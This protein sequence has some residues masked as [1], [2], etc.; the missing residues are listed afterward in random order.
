MR[1]SSLLFLIVFGTLSLQAQKY[2]TAAG[3]RLGTGIGVTLQQ[4]L[5]G[6]YTLEGIVQKGFFND[7]TTISALFEQHHKI[8]SRGT[9]FYIGAGPHIGVYNQSNKT[10]GL[11]NPVGASFIGGL[12]MRFGKML[13][14]FDYKPSVNLTGGNGF[15]D[16]QA[17]V[18]LRYI[19]LKA[20]K[21]K[22]NKDQ[23]WKFWKKKND[24]NKDE[25]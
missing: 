14:S 11:K 6:N 18:S 3:I 7:L 13:L 1:K 9:N 20:Q 15:F 16:S 25:E 22:T 23:K 12:E 24:D 2:T 5:W 4:S 21:K 10:T 8:I 19:F 17:G